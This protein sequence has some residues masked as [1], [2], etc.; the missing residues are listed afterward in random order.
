MF[1][2]TKK[3]NKKFQAINCNLRQILQQNIHILVSSRASNIFYTVQ[4]SEVKYKTSLYKMRNDAE[5]G[6]NMNREHRGFYRAD[7]LSAKLQK[8]PSSELGFTFGNRK[9]YEDTATDAMQYKNIYNILSHLLL[10]FVV[11]ARKL[12][13]LFSFILCMDSLT[14]LECTTTDS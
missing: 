6:L 9:Q 5:R 11:V 12:V 8:P 7:P 2:L 13:Y 1:R 10:L 14:V 3:H 4:E